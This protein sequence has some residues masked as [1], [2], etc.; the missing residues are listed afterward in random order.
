MCPWMNESLLNS[1]R[2]RNGLYKVYK[3]T[4]SIDDWNIFILFRNYVS[5]IINITKKKYYNDLL[6]NAPNIKAHWKT[7]NSIIKPS[8]CSHIKQIKDNQGNIQVD[9]DMLANCFNSHFVNICSTD[10]KQ[11][12]SLTFG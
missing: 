11:I 1:V 9:N 3:L 7:I 8:K 10:S 6:S 4:K 12:F 2:K 5:T